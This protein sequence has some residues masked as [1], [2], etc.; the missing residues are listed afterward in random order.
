MDHLTNRSERLGVSARAIAAVLALATVFGGVI[1]GPAQAYDRDRDYDYGRDRHHERHWHD[2]RGGY[3]YERPRGY[4][5]AP[6]PV[7]YE[8]PPPS[9]G[10]NFVFP[11]HIR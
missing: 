9:P 7:I 3:V 2:H 1:V 4:Y 8:A 6:P 10:V 5:S 11:L